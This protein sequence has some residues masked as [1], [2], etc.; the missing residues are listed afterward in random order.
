MNW[1]IALLQAENEGAGGLKGIMRRIGEGII[2]IVETFTG[3]EQ[4]TTTVY[5]DRINPINVALA[6]VLGVVLV[7]MIASIWR[8]V[9]YREIVK[10][11][12]EEKREGKKS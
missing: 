8:N 3:A 9:K 1:S 2:D 12:E 11:L 5:V 4:P 7:V 10:D 6:F